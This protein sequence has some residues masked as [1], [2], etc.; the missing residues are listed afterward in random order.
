MYLHHALFHE[1]LDGLVSFFFVRNT[2]RC[3]IS[4][5]SFSFESRQYFTL[6]LTYFLNNKNDLGK[7]IRLFG[8][9]YFIYIISTF[10]RLSLARWCARKQFMENLI[11]I[12]YTVFLGFK[13]SHGI[14]YGF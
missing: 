5:Y 8:G 3:T 6:N 13:L 9:A 1:M 11:K 4:K 7:I 14:Y 12:M 10:F 2:G